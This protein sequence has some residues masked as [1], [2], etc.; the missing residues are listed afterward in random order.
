MSWSYSFFILTLSI[1]IFLICRNRRSCYPLL[2]ILLLSSP[3]F[4]FLVRIIPR[5]LHRSFP[6][7]FLSNRYLF[8]F[9]SVFS[10]LFFPFSP[11]PFL[12]SAVFP[13]SS[14]LSLFSLLF[15]FL[16]RIISENLVKRESPHLLLTG[17][18]SEERSKIERL[19]KKITPL[20]A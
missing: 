3:N 7:F 9:L 10:S 5:F 16:F 1:F 11:L 6:A 4:F 17:I 14:C 20:S 15:L 2:L 8:F 18:Y 13:F 12:L 19:Y